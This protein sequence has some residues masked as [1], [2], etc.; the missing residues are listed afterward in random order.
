MSKKKDFNG[1][2]LAFRFLTIVVSF[3]VGYIIAKGK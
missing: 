3:L 1:V 2:Y